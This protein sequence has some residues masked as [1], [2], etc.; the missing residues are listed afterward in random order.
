MQVP[1]YRSGGYLGYDGQDTGGRHRIKH[2]GRAHP[3]KGYAN[4][5]TGS[6]N[7]ADY[8]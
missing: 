5:G 1:G 7:P 6:E 4:L 8:P 3:A 2:C